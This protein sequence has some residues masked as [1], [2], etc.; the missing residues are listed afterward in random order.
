MYALLAIMCMVGFSVGGF[1]SMNNDGMR[2]SEDPIVAT[3]YDH[4]IRASELRQLMNRRVLAINFLAECWASGSKMPPQFAE[5]FAQRIAT[6]LFGPASEE[7]VVEMWVLDERAR[8]MGMVIS[9]SAI[10]KFLRDFT[11]DQVKSDAF[12]EILGRLRASP[13]QLF[14][15]LRG[16]LMAKRLR[17]ISLA[18]AGQSTPAQ[19]WDYYRRQKQRATAEVVPVRVEDFVGEVSDAPTE[20]LLAFFDAHKEQEPDPSKPTP[21]FKVPKKA[22]FQVVVA[23]FETFYDEKAITQAEIQKHYNDFKDTRYLWEQFAL[24]DED[25]DD[26]EADEEKQPATSDDEKPAADNSEKPADKKGAGEK[27]QSSFWRAKRQLADLLAGPATAVAGL[28]AAD[29]EAPADKNEAEKTDAAKDDKPAATATDGEKP[30]E[31]DEKADAAKPTSEKTT[32]KK[33]KKS[34]PQITDELLL[35]RDIRQGTHPKHAPLWK[36]ENVIRKELAREKANEKIEA[37]LTLVREKMRKF[38]RARGAE[39]AESKMADLEKVAQKQGLSEFDTGLLTEREFKDKYPDLADAHGDQGGPSFAQIAYRSMGKFQNTTWQD[40]EGNRY[41][42]WKVEEV[43]AYVPDFAD[44]R[45]KVLRAWKMVK[46]R[47]LALAKAKKLA[48]EANTAGKPLKELFADREGLTV[49]QTPSF[50]WL[51]R[52]TANVD[53]RAPLAISEVEGVEVPGADFMREVFSLS[54]GS[55][56]EAM[57]EPQTVAYVVRVVSLEPS[58]EVLRVGFL[59]DPY[60]LYNEVAVEDQ[61][62]VRDAWMKGIEAEAHLT[63]KDTDRRRRME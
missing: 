59:A 44:V 52:G 54:V 58:R 25:F 10:N 13:T 23:K 28:L 6:R 46:A 16:E 22:A 19:R 35:K 38:T 34:P 1:V 61:I 50:S 18:G 12:N 24:S 9:D 45:S 5:M 53:N 40:V 29:D 48:E 42:T 36:V 32:A 60:Q 30:A 43:D 7:S 15:A 27:P 11:N 31:S 14:E 49:L 57:N 8:R 39:E 37:A 33:P 17:E 55:A 26:S 47:D 20:D 2:Q 3:A 4:N 63:W 56:G 41:L 51:T 21:G 62:E